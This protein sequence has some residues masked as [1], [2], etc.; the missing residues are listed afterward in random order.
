MTANLIWET[1]CGPQVPWALWPPLPS[2]WPAWPWSRGFRP[3]RIH[4]GPLG[5][6]AGR[7]RLQWSGQKP[8]AGCQPYFS[9]WLAAG[10]GPSKSGTG[11]PNEKIVQ[12]KKFKNCF[13]LNPQKISLSFTDE[14]PGRKLTLAVVLLLVK[15]KF[16][17]RQK[18]IPLK[19]IKSPMRFIRRWTHQYLLQRKSLIFW[20]K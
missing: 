8:P 11:R 13:W 16:L 10:N 7:T 14:A 18:K 12:D 5:H 9:Q 2:P 19:L 4:L 15:N 17:T 1:H 6:R 3:A 20:E